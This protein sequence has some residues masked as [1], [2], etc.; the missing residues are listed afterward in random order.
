ALV[1]DGAAADR[2]RG[3]A[4]VGH[5]HVPA[6]LLRREPARFHHGQEREPA[7]LRP[8]VGDRAPDVE[9]RL[10][11]RRLLG[12]PVFSGLHLSHTPSANASR[13]AR[14]TSTGT[15]AWRPSSS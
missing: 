14:V 12:I 13:S 6:R 9:R 15:M 3:L 10:G 5:E 4:A 1:L 11:L 2:A 8:P 7:A